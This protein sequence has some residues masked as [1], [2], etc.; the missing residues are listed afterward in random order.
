MI[1]NEP[2][3]VEART[4]D[5]AFYSQVGTTNGSASVLNGVTVAAA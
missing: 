1:I 3:D 5:I 2:F 4:S